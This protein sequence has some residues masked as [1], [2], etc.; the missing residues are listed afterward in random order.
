VP[1]ESFFCGLGGADVSAATWKE[2]ARI[3]CQAAHRGHVSE[4]WH[5]IHEGVELSQGGRP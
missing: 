2:I 5:Q 4:R 3:T 1:V